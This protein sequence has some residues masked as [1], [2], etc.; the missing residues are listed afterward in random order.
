MFKNVF[1]VRRMLSEHKFKTEVFLFGF[2][3]DFLINFLKVQIVQILL[4]DTVD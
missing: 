3:L 2:V 4:S 1:S